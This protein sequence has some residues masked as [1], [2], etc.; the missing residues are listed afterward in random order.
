M[1]FRT[2]E[3]SLR[4][5]KGKSVVEFQRNLMSE[6]WP[7]E[8]SQETADRVRHFEKRT[9]RPIKSSDLPNKGRNY[10]ARETY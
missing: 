9:G 8:M 10:N 3:S 4:A 2:R 6:G 7:R 1:H 5:L